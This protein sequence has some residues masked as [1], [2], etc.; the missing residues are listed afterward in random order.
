ME[1]IPQQTHF[2]GLRI[3]LYGPESTGKST[4]SRKLTQHYHTTQVEEFARDYLQEKYDRTQQVCSYEDILPIA[5][6]QRKAE[7]RASRQ[8][9]E[10]LFCD[11]DALETHVY[12][13][14][15]F[16]K[17]PKELTNA[18]QKSDYALYLLM[19]VDIPWMADDLRDK[20]EEREAMF[21]RFKSALEAFQKPY[22]IIHGKGEERFKNAL[23]A[24]ENLKKR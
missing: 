19:D 21:D 14:A 15:Y 13:M 24:I 22:S 18:A 4:L 2:D 6:G 16:N 10:F 9:N 20:P 7:N 5:V 1:K 12:S 8:A 11:T 23:T 3:V 17:A